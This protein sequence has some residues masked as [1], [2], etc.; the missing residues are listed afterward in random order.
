MLQR[1]MK[2]AIYGCVGGLETHWL[3]WLLCWYYIVV[4]VFDGRCI[5]T[6]WTSSLNCCSRS[7]CQFH[8]QKKVA[9]RCIRR[10]T[11][12]WLVDPTRGSVFLILNQDKCWRRTRDIM[13]R[14][15]VCDTHRQETHLQRAR[16]MVPFE[17]G[18]M[19][20]SLR[21]RRLLRTQWRA[22]VEKATRL[23]DRETEAT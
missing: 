8:L 9:R 12:L 11:S 15:D 19:I 14:C 18:R 17:S 7:L 21:L 20:P 2:M 22:Q 10:K 23:I 5:F 1:A 13:D 3:L 16:K 4:V 6:M